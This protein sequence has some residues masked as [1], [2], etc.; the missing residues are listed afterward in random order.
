MS[1]ITWLALLAVVTVLSTPAAAQPQRQPNIV[2]IMGDGI[3][4]W[5]IGAYHRGMMAGQTPNLD[6][7][8]KEGML[9]TDYFYAEAELHSGSREL[10][11]R[12]VTDPHRHYHGR[13][14]WRVGRP[15]GRGGNH[16]DGV[17]IDGLRHR[18][19]RRKPP[20]RQERVPADC[21]WL[22]RILRLLV[23]PRC[24]GRPGAS[25]LSAEPVE[26]RRPAQHGS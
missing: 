13:P 5:N 22:R 24:D 1:R 4:M 21:P 16:C 3:G 6:K 9:F 7:I 23:S 11:Y 14:G 8:A 2:V 19:V 12:G 20:W 26:C 10:H 18:P 17:E 25:R 15:A